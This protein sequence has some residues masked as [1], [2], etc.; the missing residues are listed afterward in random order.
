MDP[1]GISFLLI[2]F[3]ELL[4]RKT[5]MDFEYRICERPMDMYNRIKEDWGRICEARIKI[6][7]HDESLETRAS[8][9]GLNF[10]L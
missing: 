10:N 2:L 1:D 7:F 5:K 8:T 9:W 3:N 4:E 6:E